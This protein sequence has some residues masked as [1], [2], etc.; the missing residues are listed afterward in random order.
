MSPGSSAPP[1]LLV[2]RVAELL[3]ETD[4]WPGSSDSEPPESALA[5]ST[6]TQLG[7]RSARP[8]P[9]TDSLSSNRPNTIDLI[10]DSLVDRWSRFRGWLD[11]ARRDLERRDDLESA[12]AAWQHSGADPADLPGPG[13]LLYY[14]EWESEPLPLNPTARQF[15]KSATGRERFR[16]WRG[17][18]LIA[19]L[20]IAAGGF[21][22]LGIWALGQ[23]ERAETGEQ[24]AQTE[25][26]NALV[27]ER[28]ATAARAEAETQRL[29]AEA[30]QKLAE[31]NQHTAE[32]QT[33]LAEASASTAREQ[34]ELAISTLTSVIFEIQGGLKNVPGAGPVRRRVL[35]T[36]LTRLQEISQE[37]GDENAVDRS[38]MA[39]LVD[40]AEVFL[41]VGQGE[42]GPD[43]APAA[44]TLDAARDLFLRANAIAQRLASADPTDTRA[45]RD[46]SISYS[47]LGDVSLQAGQVQQAVD[48][49]KKDLEI[50][51]SLASADPTDA[52][53]QRDLFV[54]Y[55]C[56]GNVSLEAGQVQQAV[57]HY[58]QGLE[59][60]QRL[61]SADLTDAQA[62]RD[63]SV[64]YSR[65]GNVSL[66]AGQVQQAVDYY[67]KDL[68]IAQRLALADPTDAQAQRDLSFS[69]TK[70]G[71]T[72]LELDRP[73]EALPYFEKAL[74]IDARLATIDQSKIDSQRDLM[75]SQLNV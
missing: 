17:R 38:T 36:A 15:V 7:A 25:A 43:Q 73:Q 31:Q 24:Q 45:Q 71:G 4:G 72:L 35:N 34:T 70:I 18:A 54:S 66:Q 58:Q 40:M 41:R 64:S 14:T 30:A 27:K 61:A 2:A 29:A 56:L 12:A 23:A 48:Y 74:A 68:E 50:A 57:D 28:Q 60:A 32:Q 69:Y 19:G 37:F 49:F 33:Q 8:Q 39:A 44:G 52:Q 11:N 62:Q 55:N 46:L 47:R 5:H 22:A 65:L 9:P 75:V 13:L 20:A 3:S 21:A 10:H 6:S 42:V 59:I 26:L 63:L 51:Q 53:G 16:R 1:R 67:K